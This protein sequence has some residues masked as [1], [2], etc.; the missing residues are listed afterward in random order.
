MEDDK[1]KHIS[2]IEDL[3]E[4]DLKKMTADQAK[5]L[6]ERLGIDKKNTIDKDQ[7]QEQNEATR[8]RIKEIEAKFLRKRENK[9]NDS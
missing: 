5:M 6:R 8:N 9:D 1:F 2:S 3:T 4:E 7:L